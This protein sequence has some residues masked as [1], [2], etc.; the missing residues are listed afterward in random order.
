MAT[1]RLVLSDP[2]CF[3]VNKYGK[4]PL[5]PLKNTS[6]DFYIARAKIQLHM[7]IETM[8]LPDKAPLV[9]TRRDGENR[10]VHETD[11]IFMLITFIDEC[12]LL[13]SLPMYVTDKPDNMHSLRLFEGDLKFLSARL[14]KLDAILASHGSLLAAIFSNRQQPQQPQWP[15]NSAT[16]GVIN[17]LARP[18]VG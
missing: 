16:K 5:K 2:L 17:N 15:T 9:P 3:I 4:I 10:Q 6:I 8:N 14:D 13:D 12:K 18:A 1:R 7:D 11:D